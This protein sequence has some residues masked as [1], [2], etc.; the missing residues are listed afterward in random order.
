MK[1]GAEGHARVEANDHLGVRSGPPARTGRSSTR[2]IRMRLVAVPPGGRPVRVVDRGDRE[3]AHRSE[4]ER[5]EVP[6]RA[7]RAVDGGRG[8][9]VV[10]D[11]GRH[12]VRRPRVGAQ[13]LLIGRVG[14]Q[15]AVGSM[16]LPRPSRPR[17]SL[18]ASTASTSA[19]TLRASQRIGSAAASRSAEEVAQPLA[20]ARA[21]L[22]QDRRPADLAQLLEELALALRQLGRDDHRDEDVQVAAAGAAQA[23]HAA[24]AEPDLLPAL[25]PGGHLDLLRALDRS[26]ATPWRRGRPGRR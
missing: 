12:S 16:T 26:D 20:Q 24:A 23:G 11:A 18:T 10:G 8:V 17:I 3:L 6:E 1:P 7:L 14:G 9:R 21:A 19:S 22:G 4:V 15:R 2:P 25:R 5:L 13:R